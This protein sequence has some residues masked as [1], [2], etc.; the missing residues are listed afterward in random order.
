YFQ[1]L[2]GDCDDLISLI[3]SDPNTNQVNGL[4]VGNSYFI[5]VYSVAATSRQTFDICVTMAPEP[6]ANDN[7]DGA[8]SLTVNADYACGTVT[9]GTTVGATQSMAATPCFGTPND[10]V[11]FSFEATSTA[12]R[13]SLTNIVAVS[14]TS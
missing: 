8:V 2:S 3:C 5:R 6:P 1:V 13:I 14:G 11:W 10:D 12:H 7:C 9:A 4:T